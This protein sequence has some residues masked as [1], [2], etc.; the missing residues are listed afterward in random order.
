M[1]FYYLTHLLARWQ[2]KTFVLTKAFLISGDVCGFELVIS[3]MR[4]YEQRLQELLTLNERA[5][6]H[7][8]RA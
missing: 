5:L 8:Q 7:I 2:P 4:G 6:G 3:R 1:I